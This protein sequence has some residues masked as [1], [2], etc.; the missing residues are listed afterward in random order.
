MS[1]SIQP[2]NYLANLPNPQQSFVQGLQLGQ[3]VVN[4]Q[5]EQQ[6][7]EQ[8]RQAL[9]ELAANPTTENITRA[10]IQFPSLADKLKEPLKSVTETERSGRIESAMPIYAAL[11]SGNPDVAR[12][13]LLEMATAAENSGRTGEARRFRTLADTAR[14]S[15]DM[16]MLQI[17]GVLA[18][19]MG[20]DKFFETFKGV[21]TLPSTVQQGRAEASRTTT[22]AVF[23]P[24]SQQAALAKIYSDLDN[25]SQRLGLDAEKARTDASLKYEELRAK[26]GE[27]TSDAEKRRNDAVVLSITTGQMADQYGDLAR[28]I[29]GVITQGGVPA[30]ISE[31]SRRLLGTQND[32]TRLR[33]E[34]TRLK[35]AEVARIIP[36]PASDTDLKVF[37]E[38]FLD[39]NANPDQLAAG[40]RSMSR[41]ARIEAE[42]KAMEA[43]WLSTFGGLQNAPRG[44]QIMGVEVRPGTSLRDFTRAFVT[45]RASQM[46]PRQESETASGLLNRYGQ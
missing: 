42:T 1:Q 17:G 28:Q 34:Y 4:M 19:N 26:G 45:N 9:G 6:S 22:Q 33:T 35:N 14:I 10:M 36:K 2:P 18:A 21:S 41:L 44:A 27:L 37:M 13:R 7:Q 20:P 15:P 43:E 11:A 12:E 40:L 32:I 38:G 31:A 29:E 16:A 30:R 3:G 24:Q 5:Q 25:A 8:M 39:A 23:E 46:A